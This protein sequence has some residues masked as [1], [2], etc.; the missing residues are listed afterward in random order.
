MIELVAITDDPRQPPEP[1][2]AVRRGSLSILCAVAS[3]IAEPTADDLWRHE[4]LLERLLEDRDL[5]PVR[6]GTVVKDEAAAARVLDERHEELTAGLARVRGAVEVA[7]R[8]RSREP[9][10]EGPAAGLSGREYMDAK[11]GAS[12]SADAV[13]AP[14]AAL[15]RE[16]VIHGGDEVL[17]A[18][19]LVDRGEV[20][21]FVTAVHRLQQEH[22]EV[23]VV[24]T[25]PWPP[26]SFASG[27]SEA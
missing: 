26:F 21:A 3:S 27:R 1:L 23:A 17:R 4:E 12:R 5:L 11:A 24:C 6:Y 15:A 2:R 19:Y 22:E 14:L 8:V 7:V 20:G 9:A 18:A 16:S 10:D 25:G 13:H